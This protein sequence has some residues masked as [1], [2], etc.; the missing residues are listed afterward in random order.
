MSLAITLAPSSS[1]D[2]PVLVYDSVFTDAT[3]TVT[4]DSEVGTYLHT[5]ALDW[6]P[7]TYWQAADGE[8]YIQAQFSS[9]RSA[10]CLFI[11]APDL[12]AN[13]GTV[14]VQS[15]DDGAVWTDRTAALTLTVAAPLK[16][17]AFATASA[18]YWRAV[19]NSTPASVIPVVVVGNKLQLQRG[20]RTS[21]YT[22]PSL[23]LDVDV[24]NMESS[25]GTFLG[26]ITRVDGC[27]QMIDC[28]HFSVDWFIA[29]VR[30]FLRHAYLRPFGFAPLPTNHPDEVALLWANNIQDQSFSS[31]GKV[32]MTIDA[33][34]IC[35]NG[36][37]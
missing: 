28:Q 20:L 7:S 36:S 29:N 37:V 15:S 13:S 25:N 32:G 19:V 2:L 24:D 11:Y 12:A 23:S 21:G 31:V 5:L 10:D 17:L 18:L 26:R 30:P 6:N 8:H 14:K 1:G 35:N 33:R 4:T 22:L 34:G 16:F 9:P 27:R 3:A